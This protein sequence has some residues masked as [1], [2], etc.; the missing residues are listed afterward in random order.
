MLGMEADCRRP[1]QEDPHAG[2]VRTAAKDIQGEAD[3][4]RLS[5]RDVR[6]HRWEPGQRQTRAN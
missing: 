6:A 1:M 2:D 4:R 5:Q 3:G